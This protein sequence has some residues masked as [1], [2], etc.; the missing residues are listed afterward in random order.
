MAINLWT[1]PA[2]NLM[3]GTSVA[4]NTFTAA[5]D[6]PVGENT[7]IFPMVYGNQLQP[8]STI[9]VE[10]WGVASNTATP[11]LILGLYWGLVAGTALVVS[12]AKTTTTAMTNWE[13][14]AWY[15]G[16]IVSTGTSGSIIGSGYWRLPTSLTAWTEIRWPETAPAAVTIDTTINK[17][18]SIGATWSASSGSNSI[19]CHGMEVLVSG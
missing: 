5:K 19:T 9:R 15:T 18:L 16:R 10:A 11:T 6:I 7:T 12:T 3:P 2:Q 8:G 17:Q 4:Q 14:H 1:A 13:W